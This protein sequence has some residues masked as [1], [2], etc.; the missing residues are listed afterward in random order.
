M[1]SVVGIL[2]KRGV[3]I[4]ADSAVTRGWKKNGLENK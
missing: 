2:N 3:A 4:A 1:T